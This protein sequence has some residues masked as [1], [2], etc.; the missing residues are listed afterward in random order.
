MFS[1]NIVAFLHFTLDT[2]GSALMSKDIDMLQHVYLNIKHWIVLIRGFIT[3]QNSVIFHNDLSLHVEVTNG[4][5]DKICFVFETTFGLRPCT[6]HK[7]RI[8]TMLILPHYRIHYCLCVT[9]K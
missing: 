4:C 2:V 9:V 5:V 8:L 7:Y 6:L 1:K 3:V